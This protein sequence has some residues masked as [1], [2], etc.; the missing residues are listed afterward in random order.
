MVCDAGSPCVKAVREA[1]EGDFSLRLAANMAEC[2]LMLN[3]SEDLSL[4]IVDAP[5]RVSGFRELVDDINRQN[6]ILYG[7]PIL[8]LTD[9]E[10]READLAYLGGA[11]VDCVK[12]PLHPVILR[13]RIENS[14][15]YINSVSFA[16]FAEMLKALPANIFVKDR[17]AKY[18]FSSQI[19]RHLNTGG[20]PDWTIRGKTDMDIR[21]DKENARKALAADFSIIRTGKGTSY[22]IEENEDN[23]QEY[24]QLIKEPLKD[25]SGRVIGIIALINNVTE[26]E[27]LRKEL[28]RQSVTDRL[29]G[30]YNREYFDEYTGR[31]VAGTQFPLSILTL[32]CDDLK[33]VN[34]A[35]G[36][37]AGDEYIRSTVALLRATLPESSV[38]CRTGGDEFVI[39][40]P[41]T[42]PQKAAAYVKKLNRAA[43]SYV[44]QGIPLSVSIGHSTMRSASEPVEKYIKLSDD[45]MYQAKQQKKSV[46]GK[47][48]PAGRKAG[49]S[50]K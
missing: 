34:D 16:E 46:R 24:L 47:R 48:R 35:Y 44:V 25:E 38:M 22:I 23:V 45:S 2:A 3:N 32:D 21:F 30:L 13:K 6:A 20:D 12:K 28:K 4:L 8:L 43:P 1:T 9:D 5:S 42:S 26:Q 49:Q 36:H 50:E 27:T 33:R 41:A 11:V 10:T 14:I 7:L 29:T 40:L 37:M 18:V 15:R 31:L 39:L 17:E 19:W